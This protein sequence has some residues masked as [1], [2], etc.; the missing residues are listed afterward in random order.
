MVRAGGGLGPVWGAPQTPGQNRR[1]RRLMAL[2]WNPLL[3]PVASTHVTTNTAP[4]APAPLCVRVRVHAR[5]VPACPPLAGPLPLRLPACLPASPHV[6]VPACLPPSRLAHHEVDVG[7]LAGLVADE[8]LPDQVG[9]VD[10]GIALAAV[11]VAGGD[12]GGVTFMVS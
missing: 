4:L 7:L 12:G 1:R 8:H 11:G 10:A 3:P 9:H 2:T 5:C 6:S